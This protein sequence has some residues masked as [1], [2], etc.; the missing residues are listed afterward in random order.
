MEQMASKFPHLRDENAFGE[1]RSVLRDFITSSLCTIL[2]T[3]LP[4]S[5]DQTWLSRAR[6]VLSMPHEPWNIPEDEDDTVRHR[7]LL[8]RKFRRPRDTGFNYR[9]SAAAACIRFIRS[10]PNARIHMRQV[11]M[12]EDR[13]SVPFSECHALGL[14]PFIRENPRLR[15]TRRAHI[16]RNIFQLAGTND[17]DTACGH[18]TVTHEPKSFTGAEMM[19]TI[20]R[21]VVEHP[22]LPEESFTLIFDGEPAT[23]LCGHMG[24]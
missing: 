17:P 19:P 11:V 24:K 5:L 7:Q 21:W 9:F 15:L 16:W 18:Q 10:V 20:A 23:E 1:A 2:D 6:R 3:S 14:L 22:D 4:G 13:P 12:E 8:Y